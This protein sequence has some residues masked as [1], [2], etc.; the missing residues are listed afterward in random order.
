MKLTSLILTLLADQAG[1]LPAPRR[2]PEILAEI[3]H[4]R[5]RTE[6]VELQ[7]SSP[8]EYHDVET[9]FLDQRLDHFSKSDDPKASMTFRQR[10][11]Y[12]GRYVHDETDGQAARQTAAFLCVGG[13]GPSLKASVLVDSVHCVR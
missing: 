10:Y 12:T 11:F 8:D 1:A 2:I 9:L 4:R 5:H 13:E 6:K 3:K 7:T